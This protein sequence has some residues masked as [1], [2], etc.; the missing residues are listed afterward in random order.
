MLIRRPRGRLGMAIVRVESTSV[1]GPCVA[2]TRSL[3]LRVHSQRFLFFG[4][5]LICCAALGATQCCAQDVAE[6]ARQEQ[7]RKQS[8]HSHAKH[9]YTEE[10]L[11]HARILTPEDRAQVEARRNSQPAPAAQKP[12]EELDV[13]SLPPKPAVGSDA[14]VGPSASLGDVA[15]AYR[16]QKEAQKLRQSAQFHLPF[17]AAPALASPK[18]PVEPLLSAAKPLKASMQPDSKTNADA[19]SKSAFAPFRPFVR[20]SPFA[21]PNIF[22]A[23]PTRPFGARPPASPATGVAPS[24][25]IA[26]KR[27]TVQPGDSLWKLAERNLSNGLRWRDVLAVNPAIRDPN[28]IAAGSQIFVPAR[29]TVPAAPS[30]IKVQ[31][32]DTLSKI[33][34]TQLGRAAYYSCL[35]HANPDIRDSNLI[36][37]GQQL[38]IPTDCAP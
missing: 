14:L 25:P 33:A 31:K 11:K 8:Q 18:P 9:V 22:V 30:R 27:V 17:A 23:E 36:Y 3:S 20:R 6:A 12:N 28:H 13:Q 7:A 10:D 29:S 35:A 15:R 37:P 38:I 1:T 2:S 26:L 5:W 24:Q 4:S 32:G 16:K 19:H 21:R 34:Q